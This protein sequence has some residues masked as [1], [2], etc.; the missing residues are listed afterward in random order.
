[1][2]SQML[3]D[4]LIEQSNSLFSSLVILVKKKDGFWRFYTNYWAFNAITI[5]DDF[6]IPTKD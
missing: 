6:Q 1:M 5:K 2:V 4:G 3:K